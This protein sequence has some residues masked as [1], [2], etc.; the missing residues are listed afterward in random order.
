[1]MRRVTTQHRLFAASITPAVHATLTTQ[2]AIVAAAVAAGGVGRVPAHIRSH[3]YDPDA[4]ARWLA[5][6]REEKFSVAAINALPPEQQNARVIELWTAFGRF[7]RAMNVCP[8]GWARW[9]RLC[10]RAWGYPSYDNGGWLGRINTPYYNGQYGGVWRQRAHATIYTPPEPKAQYSTAFGRSTSSRFFTSQDNPEFGPTDVVFGD[11]GSYAIENAGSRPTTAGALPNS[12]FAPTAEVH[13]VWMQRNGAL[14]G[15]Y[16]RGLDQPAARATPTDG[17]N[18]DVMW[19][20]YTFAATPRAGAN[21]LDW[22]YGFA[23]PDVGDAVKAA[24]DEWQRSAHTDVQWTNVPLRWYYDMLRTPVTAEFGGL[25]SGPDDRLVDPA[26]TSVRPMS[27][28]D[29]LSSKS[30]DEIVREV[31]L[32][33]VQRNQA[34]QNGTGRDLATLTSAAMMDELRRQQEELRGIQSV[35]GIIQ[36]AASGIGAAIGAPLGAGGIAAGLSVGGGIGQAA[37][38]LNS[39]ISAGGAVE[40]RRVDTFGRLF[41]P[42][43]TLAIVEGSDAFTTMMQGETSPETGVSIG[44]GSTSVFSSIAL[45]GLAALTTGVFRIV[46]M[47]RGGNVE[48]GTERTATPCSWTDATETVWRCSAPLGGPF[49]LRVEDAAG[50]ARMALTG[51]SLGT[52]TDIPWA[53]MFPQHDYRITG[54]PPMTAVFVDGAPAMGTWTDATQQEW[55]VFMPQGRHD[56]RLVPPT[57]APVLASVEATGA[58]SLASWAQLQTIAAQQRQTAV[59]APSSNTGLWLALAVALGAG[60]LFVATTQ[61]DGSTKRENPRRRRLR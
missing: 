31:L 34:M 36:M 14:M 2:E 33:V 39:L 30:I 50:N 61:T 25:A 26:S 53:T 43:E 41:P 52:P 35:N 16:P 60:V 21:Y 6:C 18:L 19:Q 44:G 55:R 42:L 5:V 17:A 7:W 45:V 13:R 11:H 54:L 58:E 47:P 48:I 40:N 28:I 59:Q 20:T 37:S 38:L 51:V 23:I 4:A 8:Y 10:E 27:V 22:N 29:Y 57:G 24:K 32:D 12:A 1:M 56:V 49:W 9:R 3:W 15:G 46:G